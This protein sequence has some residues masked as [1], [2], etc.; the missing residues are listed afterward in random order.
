MGPRPSISIIGGSDVNASVRRLAFEVGNAVANSGATL[1]CGGLGGVMEA[2]A[3]GARAAG[4]HTVGILPGYERRAANRHIEFA[5]ATGM[6][7]A[8][9]AIV[10]ASGDAIIALSGEAGTLSEIGLALKLGRPVIALGAWENI[11]GIHRAETP[12]QAV[13][14]AIRLGRKTRRSGYR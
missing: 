6:G 13:A 2:A 4:G 9:N 10:V 5:V 8:R 14:L 7:Q 3:K 11:P 1:V 12:A